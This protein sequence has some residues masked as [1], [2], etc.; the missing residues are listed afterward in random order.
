MR[1]A[2]NTNKLNEHVN[3]LREEIELLDSIENVIYSYLQLNDF[4]E[5][6]NNKLLIDSLC[7][8]KHLH[9][10]ICWR[11]IQLQEIVS[12]AIGFINDNEAFL[13]ECS[14]ILSSIEDDL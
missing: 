1:F 13:E 2:V 11:I 8:I 5:Q 7:T 3:Y 10:S 14:S 9:E 4:N 6:Q 12:L